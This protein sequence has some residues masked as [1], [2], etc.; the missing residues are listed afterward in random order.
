MNLFQRLGLSR[1]ILKNLGRVDLSSTRKLQKKVKSG[2][3]CNIVA[4][5]GT[6]VSI[7]RT[8][9][10]EMGS[11]RLVI[12]DSWCKANPFCTSF[13]MLESARLLVDQTFTIYSNALVSVDK[14]AVLE[15]GGGFVN[16]GARIF[17]FNHIKIGEHVYIGEDVLIRDSDGH[18]IVG[19]SKPESMPIIIEDHVW[20]GAR[21]TVLKGVR[22]G[23]G[24]VVAAGAVVTRDVPPHGM[25]AG[26]PAKVIKEDVTWR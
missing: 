20:I 26:V 24:A 13:S 23:E 7:D 19:S 6:A 25:A 21:A 2:P 4:M 11:G 12:N 15:L 10:I 9:S 22:I 17:C 1:F 14:G 16:H 5:K 18:E 3:A 8:A